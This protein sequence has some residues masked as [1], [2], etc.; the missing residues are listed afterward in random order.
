MYS[1]NRGNG[2]HMCISLHP[3]PSLLNKQTPQW[4]A[5]LCEYLPIVVCCLAEIDAVDFPCFTGIPSDV[6]PVYSA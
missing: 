6:A 2:E 4:Q 3:P 1:W 5:W